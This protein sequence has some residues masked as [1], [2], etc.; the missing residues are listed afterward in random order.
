MLTLPISQVVN[1]ATLQSVW[2]A[3]AVLAFMLITSVLRVLSAQ[4]QSQIDV[5]NRIRESKQL[6]EGCL[7][8]LQDAEFVGEDESAN[9][10][11]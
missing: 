1:P 10:Q 6:R 7:N 2:P 8:T 4:H 11:T 9:S 5:H 3:L